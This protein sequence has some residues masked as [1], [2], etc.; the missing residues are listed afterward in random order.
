MGALLAA[1]GSLIGSILA[2]LVPAIASEIRKNNVTRQK[3]NDD[4]TQDMVSDDIWNSVNAY[5]DVRLQ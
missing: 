4:V 1:L 5:G 2:A 3:G